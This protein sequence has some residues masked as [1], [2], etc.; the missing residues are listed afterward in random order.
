M[1]SSDSPSPL[2]FVL[3]LIVLLVAGS[4]EPRIPDF[5]GEHARSG[6]GAP[7]G[8]AENAAE[9]SGQDLTDSEINER[10]FRQKR[11]DAARN[12]AIAYGL[13]ILL[14]TGLLV[15]FRPVYR[16]YLP[17]GWGP[18]SLLVGAVGVVVWVLLCKLQ[19]ES[20]FWKAVGMDTQVARP[21]INPFAVFEDDSI[22]FVFLALR[23][24]GLVAVV[25]VA[26]ELFLRGFLTRYFQS[27]EWWTAGFSR[28]GLRAALVAPVYGALTHPAEIIAAITWFAMI[29]W[30]VSRSGRF[31]DAVIAHA[32]TNLLLGIYICAFGE[33]HLW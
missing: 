27:H 1:N 17:P 12:H 16:R 28:I 26:E 3:P 6:A 9:N 4:F 31:L 33:W 30:L 13:K 24:F 23:F 11:A 19:L 20:Y 14:V 22:R 7:A 10:Y 29:T 8:S 2:P 32:T 25:P 15:S 5:A 21:S 18:A